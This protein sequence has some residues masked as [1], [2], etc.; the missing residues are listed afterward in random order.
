MGNYIIDKDDLHEDLL[1]DEHYLQSLLHVLYTKELLSMKE[2]E[3]I[4]SQLFSILTETLGYYTRNESYSVR[5]EVADKIMLSIYYTIGLFIKNNSSI[6]GSKTLI[7]EKGMKHLFTEGEKLIRLKYEECNSLLKLIQETK[8]NTN[9]YAYNDT[10]DYGLPLFF[11]EYDIRFASHEAA[12]SIDY[13]LANDEMK[14]VG[15]EY[16]EDYLN[17]INMENEFCSNFDI[18]EIEALLKGFHKNSY[19]MLINIFQLVLV[20]YLGVILIGKKEK[21]LDI[22]RNDREYIKESVKHLSKNDFIELVIEAKDKIIKELSIVNKSLIDYITESILK[23]IP[24]IENGL[25][26]DTLENIFITPDKS[27]D[28]VI[29]YEDGESVENDIFKSITEEIRDCNIVEDKIKIIREEFHSLKDLVDVLGADCIFGDEF[30]HVFE[31]LDDFEIALLLKNT[32]QGEFMDIDYGTESEREWHEKLKIYIDSFDEDR[33]MEIIRIS[34][35]V[36][37]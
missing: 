10:I 30:T 16:M 3:N 22:T 7:N 15:I 6:K 32:P 28:E 33:K 12:G 27:Q 8:L 17:K 5:V 23:V 21:S 34:Q 26:T 13:P 24:E 25:K 2:I 20:N 9:N 37:A 18:I 1:D 14:L 29:R 36:E 19:H 4:Q 11:D 31:A 35:G